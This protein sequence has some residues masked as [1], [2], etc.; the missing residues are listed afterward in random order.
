M[1]SLENNQNS[2]QLLKDKYRGKADAGGYVFIADFA[3]PEIQHQVKSVA[4][5]ADGDEGTIEEL[6]FG[7]GLRV[8]GNSGNYDT[9]KIHVDDLDEFVK[10]VK[11]HFG[12]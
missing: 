7:K 10:R 5:L 3:V 1:K 4:A 12:D 6:N 11:N 9:V 8:K 2:E